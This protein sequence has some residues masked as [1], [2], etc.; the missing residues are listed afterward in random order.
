MSDQ[1][2]IFGDEPTPPI[3]ARRR[4]LSETDRWLAEGR[5]LHPIG[6]PRK[7]WPVEGE[8]VDA[9][10][11]PYC[12]VC[13]S[14]F[15]PHAKPELYRA[16]SSLAWMDSSLDV[17]PATKARKTDP[18]TAHNAA[19]AVAK[20]GRAKNQRWQLLQTYAS[21]AGDKGLTSEQAM[22][23]APGVLP[24]SEYATRCSELQRLG[25]IAPTGKKRKGSSG[26]PRDVYL[27]TERGLEAIG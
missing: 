15:C 6:D 9:A 3:A 8:V 21:S 12:K 16:A 5:Q 24:S 14:Y 10:G 7:G 23:L 2:N 18:W 19:E 1:L 27:I 20:L 13:R 4:K 22:R 26:M 17:D 25:L 11:H